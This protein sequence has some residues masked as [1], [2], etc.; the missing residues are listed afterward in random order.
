MEAYSE[1]YAPEQLD[2][3]SAGLAGK[4]VNARIAATGSAS[5]RAYK[6]RNPEAMRSAET[7]ADKEGR[8]RKLAAGVR[9]RR[10]KQN[11]EFDI[12]DTV[13]EFLQV[14]GYAETLEEAEWIMANELDTE[15]IANILDEALTGDRAKKAIKKSTGLSYLRY[16]GSGKDASKLQTGLG[17]RGEKGKPKTSTLYGYN[18][19]RGSGNKAARR[20]GKSVYDSRQEED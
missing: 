19:D 16:H 9:S 17:G 15:D 18:Q 5:D 2:E 13:L 1:V 10:A 6:H 20:A 11:E 12:F 4:V 3:I 8:A 7:A 14:E